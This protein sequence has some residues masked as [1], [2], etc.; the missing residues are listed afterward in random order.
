MWMY[1]LYW[2]AWF[3]LLLDIHHFPFSAMIVMCVT[4]V[5]MCSYMCIYCHIFVYLCTC[6]HGGQRSTWYIS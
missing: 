5:L 2:Y 3:L 6:A 4:R 1:M